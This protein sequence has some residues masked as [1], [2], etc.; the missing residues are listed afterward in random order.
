M[1]IGS[2][3]L[4]SFPTNWLR[5]YT[6]HAYNGRVRESLEGISVIATSRKV[7][8]TLNLQSD[9]SISDSKHDRHIAKENRVTNQISTI[10]KQTMNV[11]TH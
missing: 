9:W 3:K 10:D 1:L 11:K 7:T 8:I 6:A 4:R 5:L 2:L